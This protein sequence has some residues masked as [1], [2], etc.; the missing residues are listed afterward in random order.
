[1]TSLIIALGIIIFFTI[2]EPFVRYGKEAK[3]LKTT[4]K[5][6][7]STLYLGLITVVNFI[8]LL[9]GFLLNHLKICILFDNSF[10][11]FCGILIMVGGYFIRIIAIRTLKEYYTRTLR[12][13]SDQ[14]I[15]DFGLYKYFRH[16]GYF[17]MSLF[18]IGAGLS[19]NNYLIMII[20]S[21]TILIGYHYRMNN[22]EKMLSETFGEEYKNY[23]KNTWRL[24][25]LIY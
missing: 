7:K 19:S 5:D 1:M 24:M 16:P 21:L 3:S 11:A 18:W 20:V 2:E 14:K 22:E 6:N 9:L 15:I 8:I 23:K 13:Q 4:E 25:P 17:G 10:V 12:V